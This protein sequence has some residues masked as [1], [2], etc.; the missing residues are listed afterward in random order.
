MQTLKSENFVS[1]L[2][3]IKVPDYVKKNCERGLELN[4]KGHGGDGLT[5]QTKQEARDM[6]KGEI[7]YDKC[8]RMSAWF[9]RHRSDQLGEGFHDERSPK[10]PSAGLV[11]WLLW[12][13]DANG[14]MRA[15]VWADE[16]VERIDK[17]KS[18]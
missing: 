4:R 8:K 13:G 14:S 10:Y 6:A 3:E 18:K 16:Q 15:A 5:D 1:M 2:D 17:Q 9:K 12:G 11:A 7:S